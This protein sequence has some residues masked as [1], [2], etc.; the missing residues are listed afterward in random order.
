MNHRRPRC[1]LLVGENGAVP[2]SLV[3]ALDRRGLEIVIARHPPRVMLEL[4]PIH[5]K[6]PSAE[7]ASAADPSTFHAPDSDAHDSPGYSVVIVEPQQQSRTDE[8]RRAVASYYP[9]VRC[10]RFRSH[11]RDDQPE[12]EVYADPGAATDDTSG[13]SDQPDPDS[14]EARNDAQVFLDARS[15]AAHTSALAMAENTALDTSGPLAP[16]DDAGRLVTE[17]EMAMLLGSDPSDPL[18][19]F[20]HLADPSKRSGAKPSQTPH[21]SR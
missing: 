2:S 3:V 7:V 20:P 17:Q 19:F 13:T 4:V 21:L 12:L 11:G 16:A 10:W 5:Q 1:V 9:R 15:V 18:Q 6:Q 14:G 8:L